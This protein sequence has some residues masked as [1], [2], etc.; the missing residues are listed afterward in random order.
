MIVA[1]AG[2]KGGV[3]KTTVT[4]AL[5]GACAAAGRRIL[6]VDLD[7]GATLSLWSRTA[8]EF[9]TRP[10]TTLSMGSLEGDPQ[11]LRS[12]ADGFHAVFVDCPAQDSALT[13]SAIQA[14]DRVLL[15]CSPSAADIWGLA[16]AFELLTEVGPARPG[17]RAS[18][19]LNRVDAR[20]RDH[21]ELRETLAEMGTPITDAA[22]HQ[23][24]VHTDAL[25]SG[26]FIHD[27]EPSGAAAREADALLEELGSGTH[28]TGF[29][30]VAL[31]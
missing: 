30:P 26:S 14:A 25:A 10:P 13:R 18:V 1:I 29:V 15:P 31:H 6:L 4:L 23:R 27:L 9:G 28:E 5:A 7:P 12:L 20:R 19:V 17:L 8:L 24:A 22:L 16:R 11:R 3:G 2:L 21:G